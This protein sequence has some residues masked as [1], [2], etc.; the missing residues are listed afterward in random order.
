MGMGK[1]FVLVSISFC[2][3]AGLCNWLITWRV[4]RQIKEAYEAIYMLQIPWMFW[5]HL[6]ELP[7]ANLCPYLAYCCCSL[8]MSSR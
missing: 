5:A 8:S 2:Y 4:F 3:P 6:L 7:P 1:K